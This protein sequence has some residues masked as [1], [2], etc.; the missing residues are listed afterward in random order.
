M[1]PIG[2]CPVCENVAFLLDYLDPEAVAK[3]L[4]WTMAALTR[5][6]GVHGSP[7]SP[8]FEAARSRARARAEATP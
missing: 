1:S 5:H 2:N 7:A 8:V 6:L 3:R 4:G